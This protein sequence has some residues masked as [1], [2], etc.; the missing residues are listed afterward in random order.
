MCSPD[1]QDQFPIEYKFQ[2]I[3]L[4]TFLNASLTAV[5]FFFLEIMGNDQ[6]ACQLYVILAILLNN[7]SSEK[8]TWPL[9]QRTHEKGVNILLLFLID[10]SN[11]LLMLFVSHLRSPG[12][13]KNNFRPATPTD[14]ISIYG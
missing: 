9:K 8:I 3:I 2:A 5:F 1:N 7:D 6:I 11:H 14:I 13:K 4:L 10:M 12:P